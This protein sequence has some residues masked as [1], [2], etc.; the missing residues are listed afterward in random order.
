[1]PIVN[2]K[3]QISIL[4]IRNWNLPTIHTIHQQ[5]ADFYPT[6]KELKLMRDGIL[7]L[8]ELNFYPTY[9]ELKLDLSTPISKFNFKISI[10][11]IRNWNLE[12]GIW[13]MNI[14]LISILPIRNWNC[15]YSWDCINEKTISIL[16][17]RNWNNTHL[18][19]INVI[20]IKFL[21]YL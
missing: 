9:K 2:M 10:L 18:D 20:L 16:P 5:A 1:M 21:S 14:P 8:W 11:P 4:P 15:Y 13:N 19:P 17:I 6:Y 3:P 7:W 12:T